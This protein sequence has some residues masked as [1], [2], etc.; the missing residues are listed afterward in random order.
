MLCINSAVC[1]G[2]GEVGGKQCTASIEVQVAWAQAKHGRPSD[3]CQAVLALDM[4]A[5][6]TPVLVGE[7]KEL[8]HASFGVSSTSY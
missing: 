6:P 5:D 1:M 2:C 4:T 3:A 8:P 7:T